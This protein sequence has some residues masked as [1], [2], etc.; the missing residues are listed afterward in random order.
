[1]KPQ[2][3]KGGFYKEMDK[4]MVQGRKVTATET[5]NRINSVSKLMK[6]NHAPFKKVRLK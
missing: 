5:A 6:I 2:I 4:W 3:V 1:M